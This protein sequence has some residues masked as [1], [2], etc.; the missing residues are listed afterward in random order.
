MPI[1]KSD[2]QWQE[3]SDAKTLMNAQE[4]MAN[5]EK[6]AGAK[7]GAKRIEKETQ[8][9]LKMIDKV[10]NAKRQTVKRKPVKRK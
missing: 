4:I 10:K 9:T 7:R 2:K 8:K 5:K 6:L 3:E 1:A